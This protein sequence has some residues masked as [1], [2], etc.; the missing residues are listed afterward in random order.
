MRIAGIDKDIQAQDQVMGVCQLT[1]S[2]VRSLHDRTVMG[3]RADAGKPTR[4]R[5][6]SPKLDFL[7]QTSARSWFHFVFPILGSSSRCI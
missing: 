4:L 2:S 7:M 5:F 3:L 6:T 1:P